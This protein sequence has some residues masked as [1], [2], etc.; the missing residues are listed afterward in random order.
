MWDVFLKD[1]PF[2]SAEKLKVLEA[3]CGCADFYGILREHLGDDFTFDA[4]DYSESMAAFAKKKN[5]GINVWSQDVT[6]FCASES[7]HIICIIGGLHH[8]HR[9][10]DKVL[11][12]IRRSLLPGG[13]FINLEPTHNN[14]LFALIRQVIYWKNKIFDAGT[15]RGFTTAELNTLA[16]SHGL[17]LVRQLYPGLLA[18]ILWYNP[19]AFPMLNKGSMRFAET[20]IRTEGKIW[21]NWLVRFFSFATLSCYRKEA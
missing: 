9:H 13:L 17:R 7:Y 4:F 2:P 16:R 10:V 3:M 15:E 14:P 5:P 20:L 12:N 21:S 19:D 1:I 8:V 6:T 11:R 18:Y